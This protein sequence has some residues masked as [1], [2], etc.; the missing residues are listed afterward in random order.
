MDKP[1]SNIETLQR[2]EISVRSCLWAYP[3]LEML[4][5]WTY[6]PKLLINKQN[7][8]KQGWYYGNI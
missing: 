3:Y 7:G 1:S 8:F 5:Y 4:L 6:N 2:M